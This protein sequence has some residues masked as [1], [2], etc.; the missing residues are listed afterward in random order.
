[1]PVGSL[2][3]YQAAVNWQDFNPINATL[4]SANFALK[5]HLKLYP[6]P[7]KNQ[8]SIDT[9]SLTNATLDV[10]DINGNTLFKE[11]LDAAT[12]TIN[13]SHLSDGMYFFKISS[14]E[15]SATTKVIKI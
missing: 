10:L 2:S 9:Q 5:D 7:V 12:N 6:N 15:G 13:T 14:E 1:M 8:L 4:N 3:A 11:P